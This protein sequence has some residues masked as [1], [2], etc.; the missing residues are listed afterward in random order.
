M[1]ARPTIRALVIDDSAYSRQTITRMLAASP[2]VEVVATARDGE[3]ALRKTLELRPDVVTLDLEMPRMDGFTYLRLVMAQCPTPVI[4]VSGRGGD[5]DVFKA[6]DLG[7]TDFIE[8]PTP[9]ATPELESIR[10]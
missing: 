3:D 5:A 2:L 10:D 1:R 4:V 7:A 6:L 9:H 8:K